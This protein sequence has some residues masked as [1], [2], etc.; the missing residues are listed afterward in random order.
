M[1]IGK[2]KTNHPFLFILLFVI[3]ILLWLDSFIGYETIAVDYGNYAPFYTILVGF[4]NEYRFLSVLLS[5]LIMVAQ[6]FMF[7][8]VI[9]DKN[10]VDRNSF[11]PALLFIVLMS[12]NPEFAGLHPVWL[13]NFFLIITLDKIFDVFSEDDVFLEVFNVGLFISLA[14]LFYMPALGFILLI[15]SALIIYFLVNMRGI[16]ASVIG[17][18]FPYI[19]LMLYYYWF[20]IPLSN[21]WSLFYFEGFSVLQGNW[22]LTTY[23]WILLSVLGLVGLVSFF[24]IYLGGLR[25]KPIRIRKRF[26]VLLAYLLIALLSW[27]MAGEMVSL[28]LGIVLL[29]LAAI[30][31]GFFQESKSRFWNE[32]LFSIILVMIIAGKLSLL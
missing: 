28:H 22:H 32:M 13:A 10:L 17:F 15:I 4:V 9:A 25:D 1:L 29:P 19:F 31:A 27:L 2:F 30:L 12:S 14:S 6:A 16:M 18:V 24:R 3:S 8:R 11:L 20:D 26:Q 7:N 5:F 23:D 21:L